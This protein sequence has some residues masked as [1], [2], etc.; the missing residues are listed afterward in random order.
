METPTFGDG[1]IQG[2]EG[3]VEE[4]SP[5]RSLR[6]SS[7][8]RACSQE[9]MHTSEKALCK[10]INDCPHPVIHSPVYVLAGTHDASVRMC[11][12]T[13]RRVGVHTR[14][15][16]RARVCAGAC[17]HA[18]VRVCVRAS[19]NASICAP[20]VHPH[21]VPAEQLQA[22]PSR[23]SDAQVRTQRMLRCV[24]CLAQSLAFSTEQQVLPLAS[25]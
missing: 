19:I 7:S 18:C 16:A 23:T 1:T 22:R 4:E 3:L 12:H 13:C 11:V 21:R 6:D 25:G 24:A 17:V 2:L 20:F 9:L 5:K 14:V 8:A 15:L 10:F